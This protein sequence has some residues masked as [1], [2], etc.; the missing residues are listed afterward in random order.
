[1]PEAPAA[2]GDAPSTPRLAAL[3]RGLRWLARLGVIVHAAFLPISIAGMQ[4]GLGVSLGA[5]V[6]LRVSGRR[7]WAHSPLDLPCLLLVGCAIVSLGL[8]AL[9]GS[10]PVGW[11]EATLWRSILSPLVVLSA[12]EVEGGRAA[13]DRGA[14]RRLALQVLG[15]WAAASLLPSALAWV[16]Y[17]TGFDPL[18]AMHLRAAPVH[19]TVPIYPGR[20]AAV[21]FFHWYQRL[22]H[23]LLPPLCV[24]AAVA[25]YGRVAGR[26]RALLIGA[27]IAAAAAIVLTLSRAAW[28]TLVLAAIVIVVLLSRSRGWA[29][30]AVVVASTAMAINPGVRVRIEALRVPGDN[31]DRKFIWEVCREVIGD[32]PLT[33]VG[34]GNLPRRSIPYYDRVTPWGGMRAWC[35]DSFLS[36]W[37]EG[38]PL[39]FVALAAFW[40]LLLRAF[41]RVRRSSDPLARAAGAGALAAL[42]A[43]LANSL[44]HDILYASEDV[45]ALGFALAVAMALARSGGDQLA[46]RPA[47]EIASDR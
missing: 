39:L 6:A 16:Q 24:A 4:I 36:A 25:V 7:A 37:A 10:P 26:L 8:G 28:A 42:A 47:R 45:Y 12:I 20:F 21:G 11:H 30:A 35:H 27:S 19:G 38:G 40:A 34:W 2:P 3:Q 15:V 31:D 9:G 13:G 17:W 5:L 46:A 14:S 33:G 44:V 22:A 1:M 18:Y 32:H 41:W 23:N 29:I 43:M